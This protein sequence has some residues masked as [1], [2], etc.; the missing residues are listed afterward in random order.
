MPTFLFALLAVFGNPAAASDLKLD[1]SGRIQT[2]LRFRL[3][4][5]ETGPWY[6]PF[7]HQPEIIRSQNILNTKLRATKGN[8]SGVADIDLVMIGRPDT[9]LGIEALSARRTL[10][11]FRIE[12][13]AL[14][15]EGRDLFVRGLDLRLGQQLAQ[16]GVGDTRAPNHKSVYIV[17]VQC[18]A[19]T[20]AKPWK[21]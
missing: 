21:S 10:D 20:C 17:L 3:D 13:H 2:D 12:A 11:P 8:F 1:F 6:A 7:P 15:I 19:D 4:A 9:V 18:I 16:W 14:Y 5:P